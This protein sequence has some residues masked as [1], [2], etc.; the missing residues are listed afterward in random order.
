MPSMLA[1]P[2]PVRT[3]VS[4]FV[5]AMNREDVDGLADCLAFNCVIARDDDGVSE[6]VTAHA[7]VK[8]LT[9]RFAVRPKA[10][11]TVANRVTIGDVIAHLEH[12]N[13]GARALD[14]RMALDR[15]SLG[16]IRRIDW[17]RKSSRPRG[18]ALALAAPY[19]GPTHTK[20]ERH[21]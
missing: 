14:K 10:M 21:P 18:F 9:Q 12:L 8:A 5:D 16:R 7:V 2:E 3:V 15:I 19:A 17:I 13:A 11:P 6:H 4:R 20:R 1:R